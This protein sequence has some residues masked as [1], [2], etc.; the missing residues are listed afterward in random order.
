VNPCGPPYRS[1]APP[2]VAPTHAE[3]PKEQSTTPRQGTPRPHLPSRRA[4]TFRS[5][6]HSPCEPHDTPQ[7]HTATM[8]TTQARPASDNRGLIRSLIRSALN[9]IDFCAIRFH[10]NN[11]KSS[12]N[13]LFKVLFIFRSRYLFAIGLRVIFRLARNS[14]GQLRHKSQSV[15]LYDRPNIITGSLIAE[16]ARYGAITLSGS[17]FQ[18]TLLGGP[19][20]QMCGLVLNAKAH[21]SM[22]PQVFWWGDTDYHAGL[23]PLH[24]PLLGKSPLFSFPPL[25]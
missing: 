16:R 4:R 13:S 24:S 6:P 1:S 25:I 23:F 10:F 21:R 8:T 15:R 3:Q 20:A 17:L 9:K 19:Y 2:T 22:H 18:S 14:S 7:L 5:A 12:F 11:F